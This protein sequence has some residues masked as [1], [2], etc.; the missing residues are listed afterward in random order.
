[1][2]RL[3]WQKKVLLI[4]PNISEM[5]LRIL[6]ELARDGRQSNAQLAERVGLS[7]SQC[8]QRVKKLETSGTIVGY[9]AR[10]DHE[11]LG[12][13]ETV[14]IELALDRNEGFEV[15]T[16][17]EQLAR[18]PEVLEVRMTSGEFDIFAK[19]VVSGTRGYERFLRERLYKIT[20]IRQSRSAF[21]LRSYKNEI[22]VVP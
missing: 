19:V 16:V 11:A 4:M 7:A 10:I 3:I 15:A 18:F 12:V 13:P 21:S 17:C 22:S 5:D 6:R 20:G 14:L 1:M 8:W 9:G 2:I